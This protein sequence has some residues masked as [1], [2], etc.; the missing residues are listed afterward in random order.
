MMAVRSVWEPL[1]DQPDRLPLGLQKPQAS[2]GSRPTCAVLP[3]DSDAPLLAT[4]IPVRSPAKHCE[5]E[6]QN[7]PNLLLPTSWSP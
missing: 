2:G 6:R 7:D 3:T 1:L 4:V 5:I